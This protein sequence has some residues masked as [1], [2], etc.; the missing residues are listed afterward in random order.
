MHEW[1]QAMTF[2]LLL[3]PDAV[4]LSNVLLTFALFFQIYV[5]D[6]FGG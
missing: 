6:P 2:E 4:F 3:L 5:N 1:I